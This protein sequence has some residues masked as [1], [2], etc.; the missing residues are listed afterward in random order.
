MNIS[1]NF[2]LE[3]DFGEGNLVVNDPQDDND[4]DIP[5][6]ATIFG[7]VWVSFQLSRSYSAP[8]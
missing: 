1:Y 5:E 6:D 7:D 3:G 8:A 4:D 2:N